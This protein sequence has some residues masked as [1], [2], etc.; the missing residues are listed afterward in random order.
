MISIGNPPPLAGH[1][2]CRDEPRD[3][4]YKTGGGG[5]KNIDQHWNVPK[6]GQ[7]MNEGAMKINM[8]SIIQWNNQ[9]RTQ[10]KNKIKT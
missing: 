4:E 7:I 2:K 1:G 6:Y 5:A 10:M 9:V 8:H 3:E